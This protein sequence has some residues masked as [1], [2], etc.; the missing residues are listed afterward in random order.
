MG[1]VTSRTVFIVVKSVVLEDDGTIGAG[2]ADGW[3]VVKIPNTKYQVTIGEA[4][5]E[6][7]NTKYSVDR[8][9]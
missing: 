4:I 3:A 1:T 6:I 9:E 8:R 2:G 5:G 7:P